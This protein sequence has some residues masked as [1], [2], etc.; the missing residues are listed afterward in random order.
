MGRAARDAG[1]A[2]LPRPRGGPRRRVGHEGQRPHGV[3][4]ALAVDGV[5]RGGGASR[6]G[7]GRTY[8]R[9]V[10]PPRGWGRSYSRGVTPPRWW[11]G[12]PDGKRSDGHHAGGGSGWHVVRWVEEL[13]GG[14]RGWGARRVRRGGGNDGVLVLVGAVAWVGRV[15]VPSPRLTRG[16]VCWTGRGGRVRPA[17]CW[18]AG[19]PAR[20]RVSRGGE[21]PRVGARRALRGVA[22]A[23]PD[24]PS[25]AGIGGDQGTEAGGPARNR[26]LTIV[27]RRAGTPRRATRGLCGGWQV[28]R[29]DPGN[30]H[31]DRVGPQ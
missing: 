6:R 19:S 2:L 26:L 20:W 11:S 23:E 16:G 4:V 22:R 15:G 18:S 31:G 14:H 9:G 7:W 5:H 25:G 8:S 17:G 13:G 29:H 1:A 24:N 10:T 30:L 28:S 3:D 12:K 21:G 27:A